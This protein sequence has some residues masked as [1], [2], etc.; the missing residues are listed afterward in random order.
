MS[1]AARR[2]RVRP[3]PRVYLEPPAEL[4]DRARR[5]RRPVIFRLNPGDR[6]GTAVFEGF[7]R[8]HS[9][10]WH[11]QRSTGVGGSDV[12]A[13]VGCSKW[14]SARTLYAYRT[15]EV[16]R[17]DRDDN[18]AAKH[19]GQRLEAVVVDEFA[20]QHP[21]YVVMVWPSGF[22]G[23]FRHVDRAY[24]L[25]S[26]DALLW[27]RETGQ[28]GILEVKTARHEYDWQ[29]PDVFVPIVPEYYRTQDQWY[30]DAFGFPLSFFAV[31]FSGSAYR[32][33]EVAADPFEQRVNREQVELFLECV[34]TRTPPAWDGSEST[35]ETARRIHPEID[36]DV[37]VELGGLARHLLDA[38]RAANAAQEEL[39]RAKA[40]VLAA[41]GRAHHGMMGGL[42]VVSRQ[43]KQNGTPY[44]VI[45]QKDA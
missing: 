35:Y 26:P 33:Y 39:R 30:L 32:E 24:Q 1:P 4:V 28:W 40:E 25:A 34:A 20:R 22:G 41:M 6:I 5:Y 10:D 38:N 44:P 12:A 3:S 23:S 27:H 17:Y 37:E 45:K 29:D 42:K 13:I 14:T 2:A 7:R 16:Q 19:W 9:L 21:E 43:A 18:A 36:R 31:L 8:I 11:H 15:G